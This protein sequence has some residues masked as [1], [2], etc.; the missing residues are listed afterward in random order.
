[1]ETLPIEFLINFL[2][3]TIPIIL[4]VAGLAVKLGKHLG[5]I[6][7]TLK[8]VDYMNGK[9]ETRLDNIEN[10]VKTIRNMLSRRKEGED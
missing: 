10:D 1:M 3:G 7:E 5:N 6:Q 4:T 2:L 8:Q 9:Q